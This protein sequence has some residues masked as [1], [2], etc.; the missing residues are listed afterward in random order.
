[1][2]IQTLFPITFFQAYVAAIED[3]LMLQSPNSFLILQDNSRILLN[4]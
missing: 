1:M 2:P 4:G 3:S